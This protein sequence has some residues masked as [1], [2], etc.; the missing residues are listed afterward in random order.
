M[1]YETV[2][3]R[4]ENHVATI[5][6]NRPDRLN[7]WNPRLAAELGDALAEVDGS[8]DV[9]AA[10]I[11]GAGRAFCA[12]A[13][14]AGGQFG[15]DG[16]A[17][18]G[19]R[20][21]WPNQVYKP[22]IAAIN[23]HAVGIGMTFALLCDLRIV[24]EDAKLSFAFVRRGA[25]PEMG[26]HALLPRIVSLPVA[27]DLLLS[28]RVVTGAE[29]AAIG[30]AT[31][32][33]PATDVHAAAMARAKDIVLNAAPVSVAA[34]KRLLWSSLSRSWDDTKS[35]EEAVFLSLTALPD[36]A[37]GI[38]SFIEKRRPVWSGSVPA[39]LPDVVNG[40]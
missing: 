17:P 40:V 6:L 37:E 10:V 13:D 11:T 9:R 21:R 20:H 2:E 7:A 8:D 3:Y 14:L 12:G 5:T 34:S 27:A 1:H 16:E 18:D 33:V 26:S 30:L 24:A 28:G 35:V 38:L 22:V 32:A 15:T 36:A 29:A 25:I 4:V 19:M 23:G 39:D 31:A